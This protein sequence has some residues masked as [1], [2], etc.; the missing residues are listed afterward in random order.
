MV[1]YFINPWERLN[2]GKYFL[3]ICKN[4]LFSEKYFF[5]LCGNEYLFEIIF[6]LLSLGTNYFLRNIFFQ[7]VG[8]SICLK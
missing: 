7:S 6:S 8:M 2:F 5:L 4:E 3:L 1:I